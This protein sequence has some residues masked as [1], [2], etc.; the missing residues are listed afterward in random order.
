MSHGYDIVIE[1]HG[2]WTIIAFHGVAMHLRE[3]VL[4]QRVMTAVGASPTGRIAVDLS[5]CL[6]I[7]STVMSFF[8]RL[9]DLAAQASQPHP[10]VVIGANPTIQR[11]LLAIGMGQ[12]Y[13]LAENRSALP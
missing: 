7:S 8:I 10:L 2:G 3:D 12:I 13:E 9:H 5:E 4:L 6:R 11:C 1:Q